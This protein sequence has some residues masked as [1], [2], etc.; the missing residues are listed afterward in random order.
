MTKYQALPES[1]VGG[2]LELEKVFL[3]QWAAIC[4]LYELTLHLFITYSRAKADGRRLD[5]GIAFCGEYERL[6]IVDELLKGSSLREYFKL[7]KDDASRWRLE[8]QFFQSACVLT[9]RERKI[10]SKRNDNAA[11]QQQDTTLFFVPSWEINDD[12]RLIDTFRMMESIQNDSAYRVDIFPQPLTD[13]T[14]KAFDRPI[15]ALRELAGHGGDNRISISTNSRLSRRDHNAEDALKQFEEWLDK[16][17]TTPHFQANIFAFANDAYHAKLLLHSAASEALEKGEY[18]VHDISNGKNG[19]EGYTFPAQF[20]VFHQLLFEGNEEDDRI[21]DVSFTT[22]GFYKPLNFWPTSFTY[23]EAAAFFRLPALYEGEVIQLPKETAADPEKEGIFLGRDTS[24]HNINF[25]LENFTKHAFI[26]GTPGH[27]KTN[28]MLH[29]TSTLWKKYGIPFLVFEP[30]KKEYRVLFNDPD[31]KDMMIFS[32][33][34]GTLFPISVNPF[35]FSVGLTLSEHI[36]AL[37]DVFSG[38]FNVRLSVSY[39]L[40]KAIEETYYELGWESDTVNDGTLPYPILQD[41]M[42]IYRKETEGSEYSTELKGWLN[43]FLLVQ[44]G[45]LRS[46]ELDE[47]FNIPYSSVKPEDWIEKP[48]IFELESLG[49]GARNFFILL[50]CSLIRESLK[51]SPNIKTK[52]GL[53]HVIF[54]EEAHNLIA[55]QTEQPSEELVN[56]KISATAFIVKMLAEVRALGEGIVIADQLP[57]AIA[58]E[59][60]KNTGLKILHRMTAVDDRNIVGSTMSATPAQQE[61]V[62]TYDKGDALIFYEGLQMPFRGTIEMWER[63]KQEKGEISIKPKSNDELTALIEKN[64]NQSAAMGKTLSAIVLKLITAYIYGIGKDLET[65]SRV[66]YMLDNALLKAQE[67]PIREGRVKFN[68]K[69]QKGTE[70]FYSLM[71]KC[72]R[73]ITSLERNI[74]KLRARFPKFESVTDEIDRIRI[75]ASSCYNIYIDDFEELRK[76]KDSFINSGDMEDGIEISKS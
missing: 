76:K 5:I 12:A 31:M 67:G 9:K 63:E 74:K 19:V 50:L 15:T 53:R 69:Y 41:V 56:A 61:Q 28:T 65:S 6:E 72:R 1:D 30:A 43:A 46:R 48:A 42:A 45:S 23:E 51:V 71:A 4:A 62:G 59:V 64:E 58:S 27:G 13:K 25:P 16:I 17:E 10:V 66:I 55:V 52:H 54:V 22:D 32:P 34:A 75:K 36:S 7:S 38:A 2:L 24:G 11:V 14:R 18:T 68:E 44:L 21:K 8:K 35:E 26:S 73:D 57:S 40:N 37:M 3:R 20:H 60:M 29:M 49:Q 39:Y 33:N 47:M 70:E